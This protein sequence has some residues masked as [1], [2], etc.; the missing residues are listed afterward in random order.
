MLFALFFNLFEKVKCWRKLNRTFR[1]ITYKY[2]LQSYLSSVLHPIFVI[3]LMGGLYVV[4]TCRLMILLC[5][6]L[7]W[8]FFSLVQEISFV[9]NLRLIPFYSTILCPCVSLILIC[10][11]LVWL[12]CVLFNIFAMVFSSVLHRCL[13]THLEYAFESALLC[14]VWSLLEC[15][16]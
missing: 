9:N 13:H 6:L 12:F 1:F 15:S 2:F 14:A 5:K 4:G 16:M 7:L 8:I 10:H 3:C 11:I